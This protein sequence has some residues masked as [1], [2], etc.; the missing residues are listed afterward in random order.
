MESR[1]RSHIVQ[2]IVR[3][4]GRRF[5]VGRLLQLRLLLGLLVLASLVYLGFTLSR[6]GADYRETGSLSALW[7]RE[8]DSGQS[9]TR[10]LQ[11]SLFQFFVMV[12]CWSL[13]LRYRFNK[14]GHL[15]LRRSE[16]KYR[17]II[18]HAGEAIFL[19]DDKGRVLE[20][21]K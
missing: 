19:L 21:N 15:R 5:G 1:T 7:S 20:W 17:S 18:N 2:R 11:D 6:L 10:M 4:L 12:L 16:Q 13:F 9:V 14:L 8:W 3:G